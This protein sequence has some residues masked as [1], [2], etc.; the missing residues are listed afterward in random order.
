MS[1]NARI[2]VVGVTGVVGRQALGALLDAGIPAE[3]ITALASE[4]SEGEEIE[5]GS[6]TLSVERAAPEVFRG[7]RAVVLAVPEQVA[8]TSGPAA[9]AA[10]AWVVDVST[11]FRGDA[12][13]PLVLPAVNADV[14]ER[15]FRGRIVAAPSPLTTTVLTALEPLRRSFGLRRASVTALY[16]ASSSGQR[17]VSELERQT[18]GLL[19]GREDEPEV[20]PHRLGFNVIPQVGEFDGPW[21]REEH[22]LPE[23]AARIW[24]GRGEIPVLS[25]TV[26]QIPTFYGHAVTLSVELGSRPGDDEV[27][28]ALKK[29]PNLKVLD[30]PAEKIY[31][32]PML[33]T[34]DPT[35]HVGRVRSVP[36]APG[37]F[38]LMA[39]LDNAGRGAALNAV[40]IA[41]ALIARP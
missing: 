2:A 33:I 5:Y 38:E 7:H 39:V 27:R 9:Q 37:H 30:A 17:G 35:V 3:D 24:E 20:F 15:P 10:G 34:S 18:A 4:R 25:A 23:E 14:L 36:R 32:M 31:P 21:T 12:S 8:R 19:S 13:V 40:E 22:A 1:T 16:G 28:E 26:L 11:A 41:R 29:S 6:E